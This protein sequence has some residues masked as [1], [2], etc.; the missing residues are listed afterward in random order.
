MDIR[1]PH[2]KVQLTGVDGNA[3]SILAAC[4][5]AM[6]Q[7]GVTTKEIDLFMEET[8]SGDYNHLLRTCQLW[9]NV[10]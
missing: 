3:F 2:I 1:Y 5:K 7:N 6:R 10:R 8:M 4:S 9:V